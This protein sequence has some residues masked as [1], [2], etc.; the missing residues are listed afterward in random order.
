MHTG[1]KSWSGSSEGG[2]GCLLHARVFV[3]E[4]YGEPIKEFIGTADSKLWKHFEGRH[5][6]QWVFILKSRKEHLVG[7]HNHVLRNMT[8]STNAVFSGHGEGFVFPSY[9]SL[10]ERALCERHD[11]GRVEG[12]PRSK[13]W[14]VRSI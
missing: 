10:G 7:R 3:V 13:G 5:S 4:Q 9:F 8:Q 6:N 12:A 1:W 11:V 2:T 14:L